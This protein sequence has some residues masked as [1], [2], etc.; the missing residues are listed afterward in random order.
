MLPCIL[1]TPTSFPGFSPLGTRLFLQLVA[2][3]SFKPLKNNRDF[4]Q[5]TTAL[6]TTAVL[7]AESWGEYFTVAC[8][9]STLSRR[10]PNS[11]YG[12]SRSLAF[13]GGKT[14][15][16]SNNWKTRNVKYL[17]DKAKNSL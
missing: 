15:G 8:Q 17:L 5:I 9:I 13:A 3:V 4:K 14:Q 6:S 1:F 2:P 11:D 16:R 10:H 12:V 7:D